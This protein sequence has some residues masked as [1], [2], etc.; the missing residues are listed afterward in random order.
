MQIQYIG[1]NYTH[2]LDFKIS[3]PNGSGN[4]L[5]LIVKSPATFYL[6]G[7]LIH[8]P[9]NTFFLYKKGTPQYYEAYK[10]PFSNDWFHFDL[11]PNEVHYLEQLNI[12][13]NTP[14][15][16]Q[17]VSFFSLLIKQMAYEVYADNPYKSITLDR[18]FQ[19]FFIKIA[20]S[21]NAIQETELTPRHQQLDLLRSKIYNFPYKK[22]TVERLAHEIALSP[23]YFHK[24]YKKRFGITC[25]N[26]I[27]NARIELAKYNL[28]QTELSIK[29]IAE[30]CGYANDV[31]FMR[32]FKKLTQLTP[33]EYRLQHMQKMEFTS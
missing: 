3:R 1:H 28:T 19:I 18:Y 14:V 8:T 21:H 33:S 12:P 10:Q 26:D 6:D 30:L 25:A 11:E 9:P 17:D 24:L 16:L 7:Q 13:F 20:E 22:W 15:S 29:N 5:A 23:C 27:I 2:D 4:Y 32:Q 31:H